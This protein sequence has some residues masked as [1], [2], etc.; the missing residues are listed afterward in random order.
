MLQR[1]RCFSVYAPGIDP[2]SPTRLVIV[3]ISV[4]LAA[5]CVLL[6]SVAAAQEQAVHEGVNS[7]SV[8]AAHLLETDALSASVVELPVITEVDFDDFESLFGPMYGPVLS[9][10]RSEAVEIGPGVVLTAVYGDS[11]LGDGRLVF[12]DIEEPGGLRTSAFVYYDG[13][14]Q[15]QILR[16]ISIDSPVRNQYLGHTPYLAAT[17]DAVYILF[18]EE[19]PTLGEFKLGSSEVR[20]LPAF[21]EDFRCRPQL[22]RNPGWAE[23]RQTTAFCEILEASTMAAGLYARQG[24]LFL[25]GKEVADDGKPTWSLMELN[26]HTGGEIARVTLPTTAR[27]LAVLPIQDS[28]ALLERGAVEG[29]GEMHAPHMP[30]LGGLLISTICPEPDM[31][32]PGLIERCVPVIEARFKK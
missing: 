31:R 15:H 24:Q 23:A 6:A 29:V 12:G 7:L 25:L 2:Q 21:P 13:L 30:G 20:M 3:G 5:S 26:P 1:L 8:R 19:E 28:W 17:D 32:P 18:L 27:N 4:L 14:G 22:S 16:R 10:R 11:T 9:E